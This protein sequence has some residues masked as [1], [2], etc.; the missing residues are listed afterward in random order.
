[1]FGYQHYHTLMSIY[2]SR[3]QEH[4]Q[5]LIS[6]DG[7]GHWHL[8]ALAQD[9]GCRAGKLLLNFP[10]TPEQREL[11]DPPVARIDRANLGPDS[12]IL[13]AGRPLIDR[14]TRS[15]RGHT[16]LEDLM[17]ARCSEYLERSYRDH[18]VLREH[19]RP[20]LVASYEERWEIYLGKRSGSRYQELGRIN[21][22][23]RRVWRNGPATAAVLLFLRELWPAGPGLV[24]AFGWDSYT[25]AAWT[26]FLRERF[27]RLLDAPCFALAELTEVS[28]PD[29]PT[30]MSFAS[31]WK[32]EIILHHPIAS[33]QPARAPSRRRA[34]G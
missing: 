20:F 7:A 13:V 12:V 16:D 28:I 31:G 11:S 19:L 8:I 5:G 9:L 18:L 17:I 23:P 6:R 30:D 25:T 21:D 1:M 4:R 26:L 10:P 27:S 34:A 32:A 14:R 3:D 29:R 33:M 24:L 22:Q 15:A 2:P